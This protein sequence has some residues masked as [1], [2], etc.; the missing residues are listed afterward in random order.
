VLADADRVWKPEQQLAFILDD[1]ARH[2][3][4]EGFAYSDT[5]YL[6]LGMIA[7]K[8][9]GKRYYDL[10]AERYLDPHGF[11]EIRPTNTRRVTDL[12]AGYAGDRDP[13]GFPAKMVV[14]GVAQA[15]LQFEWTG[16]GYA[17]SP[18]QLARFAKMLYEG[19]FHD[20]K[21]LALMLEDVE[22]PELRA[23]YG[24]GVIVRDTPHG[25]SWGHS[26]FMPGYRTSMFYFPEHRIA[27]AAQINS[28][29]RAHMRAFRGVVDQ[30]I[31]KLL[32]ILE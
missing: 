21:T 17:T 14:D 6:L 5:N 20:A 29:Q 3:A 16:G 2:P 22:A 10:V 24:A 15:N 31:A 8:V 27:V 18:R 12:A 28:T 25:E 11:D 9:T 32:A 7:E 26:G 30:V 19:S 23:R 1:E 13:L 4:G